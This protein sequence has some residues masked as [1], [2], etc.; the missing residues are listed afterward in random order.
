MTERSLLRLL[1]VLIGVI[2]LG[3]TAMMALSALKKEAQ[4]KDKLS[5]DDSGLK[6]QD[7]RIKSPDTSPGKAGTLTPSLFDNPLPLKRFTLTDQTGQPFGSKQL[8]GKVWIASFIFTRCPTICPRVLAQTAQLQ[9]SLKGP[10][11]SPMWEH[12][13][14]VSLSV[15]PLHDSPKVLAATA[16]NWQADAA[17]WRFLTTSDRDH[18]WSLIRGGDGFRQAVKEA[19]PGS[20]MLIAHTSK[21]VLVD[22]QH[23]IRGFY[24]SLVEAERKRMMEDVMRLVEKEAQSGK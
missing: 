23:Q 24:D 14:F 11:Q 12:L 3:V 16:D 9:A 5:T 22:Q 21:Y 4:T 15:D 10:P 8:E 2:C 1:F 7:S 17:R 13:I 18:M 6:P 20:E 19:D